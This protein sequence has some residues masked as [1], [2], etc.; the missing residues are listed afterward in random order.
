MTSKM[1]SH[2]PETYQTLRSIARFLSRETL[3]SFE[4][5]RRDEVFE[6]D[7]ARIARMHRSDWSF[8]RWATLPTCFLGCHLDIYIAIIRACP[9]RILQQAYNTR[10]YNTLERV[11]VQ[12]ID[13]SE[14]THANCES[15]V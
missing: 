13:S 11:A 2:L 6:I 8:G 14:I 10:N 5:T 15:K 4:Q 7:E 9:S 12:Q 3:H 1:H